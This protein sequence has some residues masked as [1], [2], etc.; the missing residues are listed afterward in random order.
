MNAY[1]RSRGPEG[2]HQRA[3]TTDPSTL[4]RLGGYCVEGLGSSL[5]MPIAPS[6]LYQGPYLWLLLTTSKPPSSLPVWIV[7]LAQEGQKQAWLKERKKKKKI[8]Q[9]IKKRGLAGA[10]HSPVDTS[11][12]HTFPEGHRKRDKH[13][14]SSD[15][16]PAPTPELAGPPVLSS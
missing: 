8:T 9:E 7:L 12:R 5:Y 11:G 16:S 14:W 2:H 1:Q 3:H 4:E 15:T 13:R 10:D 6:S